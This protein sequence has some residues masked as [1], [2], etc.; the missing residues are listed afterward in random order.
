MPPAGAENDVASA[1]QFARETWQTGNIRP[2]LAANRASSEVEG[3]FFHAVPSVVGPVKK[4]NT[5]LPDRGAPVG[6]IF[7]R[8]ARHCELAFFRRDDR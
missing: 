8:A 4:S 6:S 5:G 3:I 7:L 1:H 2:L